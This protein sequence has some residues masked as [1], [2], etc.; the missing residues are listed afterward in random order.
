MPFRIQPYR[1]RLLNRLVKAAPVDWVPRGQV[2]VAAGEVARDVVLVREGWLARLHDASPDPSPPSGSSSSSAPSG[3]REIACR[4]VDVVLPWELGGFEALLRDG[5]RR[6]WT[7][8]A[9]TKVAIQRMPGHRVRSVLKRSET[10]FDAFW[11]SVLGSVGLQ[12]GLGHG[13]RAAEA[14]A[15]E[16]LWAVL[17]HLAERSQAPGPGTGPASEADDG[18]GEADALRLPISL[19]HRVLGDMSGLH[20]ST[21]TTL[22]NEWIYLDRVEER[23]QGWR[24]VEPGAGPPE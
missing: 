1:D 22:L 13:R 15:S 6:R 16:R 10:T 23:G 12:E 14:S 5:A 4:V 19:P 18:A 24:I 7:L 3:S 2:V 9:Q 17:V 11:S 8:E 21:V 20:R